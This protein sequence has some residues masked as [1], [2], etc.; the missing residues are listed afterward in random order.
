MANQVDYVIDF[1]FD[2]VQSKYAV[3]CSRKTTGAIWLGARFQRGKYIPDTRIKGTNFSVAAYTLNDVPVYYTSS[4]LLDVTGLMRRSNSALKEVFLDIDYVWLHS[5]QHP[6]SFSKV[7]IN[8]TTGII[9][10]PGEYSYLWG[11]RIG[12]PMLCV[13]AGK[14]QKYGSVMITTYAIGILFLTRDTGLYFTVDGSGT[15]RPGYWTSLHR[16]SKMISPSK[17]HV[18]SG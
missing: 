11:D 15:C 7:K 4:R 3:G 6:L 5:G 9:E 14:F 17:Q 16:C 13:A 1:S 8:I 2:P 18:P 12:E 10:E